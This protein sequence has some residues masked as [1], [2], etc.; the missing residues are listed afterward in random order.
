MNILSSLDS[1]GE[2][3][4]SIVAEMLRTVRQL[5]PDLHKSLAWMLENPIKDVIFETFSVEVP[6]PNNQSCVLPLCAGG[7]KIEVTDSNKWEYV[8]L[9]LLW[10]LQYSIEGRLQPFLAGFHE[11]VPLSVLQDAKTEGDELHLMLVGRESIDVDEL[12]A[13]CS[14]SV[15]IED[16][17]MSEGI[18]NSSTLL[19]GFGETHEVVEWLWRLCREVSDE[20]VRSL[21]RFFTGSSRVPLD[22]FDPALKISFLP[23]GL[24]NSLPEAHTC[25]NQLVLPR[26]SSYG[27]MKERVLFAI[28]NSVG[29]E[30]S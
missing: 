11:M 13:F 29:F 24:M 2:G 19:E 23:H 7:D 26:Y 12:R 21:L 1:E 25:F 9:Q 30:L 16:G 14:Y 18:D 22:G 3:L 15:I 6:G 17:Q 5:E 20:E 28:N 4:K 8:R 27:K 10:K